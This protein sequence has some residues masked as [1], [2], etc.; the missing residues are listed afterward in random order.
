[1]QIM[2]IFLPGIKVEAEMKG[3]CLWRAT[4]ISDIH[5][6]E[7]WSGLASM[8]SVSS[9][10]SP[11]LAHPQRYYRGNEEAQDPP[12]PIGSRGQYF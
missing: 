11:P 7:K 1:M 5:Q 9:I 2:F 3:A 8:K 4:F 12:L 10:T 6:G